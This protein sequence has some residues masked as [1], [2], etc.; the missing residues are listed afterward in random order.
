VDHGSIEERKSVVQ[1]FL[2]RIE[3]SAK[4]NSLAAYFYTLPTNC[5]FEVVAGARYEP[6][7]IE[8]RP[9]DRYLAGLRSAA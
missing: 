6:V 7:Q 9:L 1:S 2:Q 3:P 8:M 4:D 5:S